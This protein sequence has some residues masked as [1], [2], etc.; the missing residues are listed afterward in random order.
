MGPQAGLNRWG[1]QAWRRSD[2]EGTGTRRGPAALDA[3]ADGGTHGP[4][5]GGGSSALA[6]EQAERLLAERRASLEEARAKEKVAAE[7]ARLQAAEAARM[8][9][10]QEEQRRRAEADAAAAADMLRRTSQ[11]VAEA[12]AAE[13]ARLE[14]ERMELV[15]R[16]SPEELRRAQELHAHQSAVAAAG[17]GTAQAAAGAQ[18]LLAQGLQP[19]TSGSGAPQRDDDTDRIMSMSPA[20]LAEWDREAQRDPM[21]EGHCPW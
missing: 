21:A 8:Q 18:Q 6:K 12:E 17:F 19:P 16:T 4:L 20:E 5:C 1:G 7:A 15:A 3:D 9:Q 2:G 13:A 14:K 11:A 10:L